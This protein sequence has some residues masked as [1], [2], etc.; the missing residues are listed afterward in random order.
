[1]LHTEQGTVELLTSND[2]H[3]RAIHQELLP[4]SLHHHFHFL[5]REG[6]IHQHVGYDGQ[7][8]RK[9]FV[10]RIERDKAIV[11]RRRKFQP[12]TI[13]IQ[14]L[15]YLGGC[16]RSGPLTKHTV[17]E[18][19]LQGLCLMPLASSYQYVQTHHLLRTGTDDI[20]GHT[21]LH[22]E[23]FRTEQ[24]EIPHRTDGGRCL[25]I[26]AHALASSCCFKNA[27]AFSKSS[28]V[29]IPMVSTWLIPTLMVYPFSNQRS[30]SND[31]ATSNDD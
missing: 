13:V 7:G 3:P 6:R 11:H 12:S 24:L 9:V 16:Q 10:E 22:P 19:G 5:L 31:S 17:G 14:F 1:M 23:T 2:L 26:Q 27:S 25:A 28:G 20:Q 29:S 4:V 15:G 30:C 8:M 21:I 18:Q